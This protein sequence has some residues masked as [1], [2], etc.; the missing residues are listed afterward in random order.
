VDQCRCITNL[1]I[2]SSVD[3]K[4][5]LLWLKKFTF[6]ICTNLFF[7]MCRFFFHA[8]RT[9]RHWILMPVR[10]LVRHWFGRQEANL[11]E[12]V[13][14]GNVNGGGGGGEDGVAPRPE[15]RAAVARMVA[16]QQG[17]VPPVSAAPSTSR[18]KSAADRPSQEGQESQQ[19]AAE[20]LAAAQRAQVNI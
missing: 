15:E 8:T 12:D 6:E 3:V 4:V 20:L 13:L 14:V 9:T 10:G 1:F 2:F 16:R 5:M 17:R 7:P 11:L 18:S 19:L